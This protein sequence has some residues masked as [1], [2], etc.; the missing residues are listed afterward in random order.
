M[1]YPSTTDN[2][3]HLYRFHGGLHI[4]DNKAQSTSLPV[5]RAALPERLILPLQQHIG[6]VSK[7]LVVV[8]EQVLKGQM[9]AEPQGRVSSPIHAP[10]AHPRN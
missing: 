3:R 7:P 6:A 5:V 4:P 8:G 2:S 9:I 10:T 1:H